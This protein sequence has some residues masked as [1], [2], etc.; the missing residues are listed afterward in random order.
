MKDEKQLRE[1]LR[2][3]RVEQKKM[4]ADKQ[5]AQAE[6]FTLEGKMPRPLFST[7]TQSL[8]NYYQQRFSEQDTLI[9]YLQWFLGEEE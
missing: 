9:E 1:R 6:L 4:I 3:L 7:L 2:E 8:V 5:A